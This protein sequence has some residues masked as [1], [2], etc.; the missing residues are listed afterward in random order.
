MR[1]RGRLIVWPVYLDSTFSRRRGRRVPSALASKNVKAEEIY[2][3][4]SKLG[5]NAELLAAAHPRMPWRKTGM[6]LVE[7]DRPK[8]R[9]LREL[10]VTIRSMRKRRTKED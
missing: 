6:V 7:G 4:V 9:L 10:A 1:R 8:N 2:I 3:A 5:L